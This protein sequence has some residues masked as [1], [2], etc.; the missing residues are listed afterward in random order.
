[1][2]V[3]PSDFRTGFSSHSTR[4]VH[5]TRP[6]GRVLG[7]NYSSFLDLTCNSEQTSGFFVSEIAP[8]GTVQNSNLQALSGCQILS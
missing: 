2:L 7:K 5:S 6:T 3:S 8:E 1:M 4:P